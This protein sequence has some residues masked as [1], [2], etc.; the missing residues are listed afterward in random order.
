MKCLI[1][2]TFLIVLLSCSHREEELPPPNIVWV[3]IEDLSPMLGVYGDAAAQ[4][5]HLDAFAKQSI[6]FT[7]AF[8]PAPVCSP[9]RSC[10]I[11]GYYGTSLGSMNLR[12]EVTLPASIIPY[13]KYLRQAGYYTSNNVKEDYNFIDTTIWDNSSSQAH[14]RDRKPGQPFFSIFNLMLTHQSSIFGDDSVYENR[15]HS[16]LPHITRTL[17]DQVNLPPYYP[18]TPMIRKLW[19]RYYTN[20]A[21]VDY[22]FSKIMEEL[23]ADGLI[24]STIVFF[25]SDHG[26]G[27]PRH[28]RALHDSGMKVPF[29]IHIPE[30]YAAKFKF[31]ANSINDNLISFIDLA[32]TLFEMAGISIPA[33]YPGKPIIFKDNVIERTHLY[34]A[35][36]RV[37]EGFDLARS[38]RTK[39]YLYIRNFLPHLPLLQP[40]WYTDHSEIMK[41]LNRIRHDKNL[42]EPQK[43]MFAPNRP[44]EELYDVDKDP[45]QLH[46]LATKAELKQTLDELRNTL[47]QEILKNAD[48]GF[49]PEPELFRLS[50]GSTPFEFARNQNRYPLKKILEVNDLILQPETAASEI[51]R[52]LDDSE[53]LIRYWAIIG[54]RTLNI[55]ND[56]VNKKLNALLKDE[57]ATVQIEAAK[58]LVERGDEKAASIIAGHMLAEDEILVL[59]ACRSFQQVAN[60]V[61]RIPANARKAYE[62]LADETDSGRI[63]NKFYPLY[64]Y[65]ALTYVFEEDPA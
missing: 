32:P 48:T 53:G 45:H 33:G 21:I 20:V 42:T 37:D 18:D 36:D 12:S 52:Y 8:A 38:I 54:L 3:T 35:S 47:Q 14:W 65:W 44:I 29:M 55:D 1:S 57:F 28:K 16:F 50:K 34:G 31:N 5:P 56:A 59:F 7:N 60:K 9:S 17:P 49:A 24:E 22:Q 10:I 6:R 11:T 64:S 63:R 62:K 40:N 2:I 15:V 26:T 58:L 23:E 19:A 13:P 39:K 41:E 30:K 27:M 61:N 51:I 25:Y 43:D 4:T 46:N